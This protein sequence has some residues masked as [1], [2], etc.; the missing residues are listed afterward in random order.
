MATFGRSKRR[1]TAWPFG[2]T[3]SCGPTPRYGLP[4]SSRRADPHQRPWKRASLSRRVEGC[5]RVSVGL[6]ECPGR[7]ML[8]TE[9]SLDAGHPCSPNLAGRRIGRHD[10]AGFLDGPDDLR[11]LVP[12]RIAARLEDVV[13]D[14]VIGHL[15]GRVEGLEPSP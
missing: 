6:F 11:S 4:P 15:V 3:C 7:A 12:D 2:R 1:A 5:L 10:E 13:P 14:R 9:R 8:A